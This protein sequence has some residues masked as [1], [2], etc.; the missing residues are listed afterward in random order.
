[1]KSA[2]LSLQMLQLPDVAAELNV[3]V[4]TVRR[5]IERGELRSYDLSHEPDGPNHYRLIRV[6]RADLDAYLAETG[7]PAMTLVEASVALGIGWSAV[8]KAV[9]DGR[10][11]TL[12][13]GR[14]PVVQVR[15]FG[16]RP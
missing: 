15:A 1:M 10:L 14:I 11:K 13:N 7:E 12:P 3:S 8:R 2:D 4:K 9:A 6:S 16:G 5:L